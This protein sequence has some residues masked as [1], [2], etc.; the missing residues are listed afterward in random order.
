MLQKMINFTI[1]TYTYIFNY[2]YL[3]TGCTFTDLHYSYRLGISTISYIVRAVCGGIISALEEVCIMRPNKQMWLDIVEGFDT[4][5]NFPHCLGAVDGKHVRIIKPHGSGS[6]FY[7][8]KNYFSIVVMAVVDSNYKFIY[9]QVGAYGKDC[10]SSIFKN[11]NFW[12]GIENGTFDIPSA[13]I[14]PGIDKAIPYFFIGD[15]GFALHKHLLRPFGGSMLSIKKRIFN[16]R[17]CRARRYVECA[18]G[19]LSNKWRIFHRPLNVNIDFATTLVKTCIILHNFVRDEDG[20]NFE[21]TLTIN[22][23]G[24]LQQSTSVRGGTLANDVRNSL[25]DYFLSVNGSVSWQINKI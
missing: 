22:G 8:Y 16:Y 6:L 17:H 10:D 4:R 9:A 11:S 21:D 23:F 18:F 7:N 25:A 1:Y 14:L 5:A 12:K 20:I 15:E 13:E 19:I 24:N 2:R 3:A